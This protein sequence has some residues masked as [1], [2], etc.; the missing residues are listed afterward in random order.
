M[1]MKIKRAEEEARIAIERGK[2]ARNESADNKE[3]A[4]AIA[5]VTKLKGQMATQDRQL[6]RRRQ[7]IINQL[8]VETERRR[9]NIEAIEEEAKARYEAHQDLM[10]S[11]TGDPL[12][13][14][15][16]QRQQRL[17]ELL[18][19]F[20]HKKKAVEFE[21]QH[22]IQALY[23]ETNDEIASLQ[24]ER[25]E[26]VLALKKK[27]ETEGMTS[28][29]AEAE[30]R[31]EIKRRMSAEITAIEEGMAIKEKTI[32]ENANNEI[33]DIEYESLQKQ[34]GIREQVGQMRAQQIMSQAALEKALM[35]GMHREL[36]EIEA[37][38]AVR[39]NELL[40]ENMKSGMEQEEALR[41]ARQQ[42]QMEFAEE[43]AQTM[44]AIDEQEMQDRLAMMQAY[45]DL[46]F[47]VMNAAFG[48]TKA[49][50]VAQAIIDTYAGA[51]SALA[52]PGGKLGIVQAAAT[53][54]MGLANVRKILSTDVGDSPSGGGGG[55]ASGGLSSQM[56]YEVVDSSVEGGVARQ[57]AEQAES[58]QVEASTNIYLQ[59]DLNKEMMAIKA[60][61]GNRT[62][63]TKTLTTKSRQ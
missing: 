59:G 54:A 40:I 8:E 48:D 11:A 13:T 58:Q 57:V 25:E 1:Q 52:D 24:E 46:A 3:I 36:A 49:V 60:R 10:T 18:G 37:E 63:N 16:E 6:T 62:I 53:I 29:E 22:E 38:E 5:Q 28:D 43:K 4:E 55:T 23:R 50:R 35:R 17:V 26:R 14:L 51:N 9:K 47:G 45:T 56:G 15:E 44:I 21:M 27:Y 19:K 31:A 39:R 32:R 30:A 33:E 2:M 12:L 34:K 41:L 7:S 61:E 20:G 42:A